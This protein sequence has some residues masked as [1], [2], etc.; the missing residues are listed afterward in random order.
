MADRLGARRLRK[1]VD[2]EGLADR[3]EGRAE[4]R[5]GERVA[6]PQ[7]REPVALGKGPQDDE[8]LR[9][10][11]EVDGLLRVVVE[12]VLGV[13]LVE[14][15][16]DVVGHG[17]DELG[18]AGDREYGSRSGCSGLQTRTIWVAAVISSSIA[19]RSCS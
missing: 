16:A 14:D 15:H 6:H 18:D 4:L 5:R 7:P 3:V 2:A 19:S 8:V 1:R 10:A 17:I 13:R 11:P 12:L 9:A